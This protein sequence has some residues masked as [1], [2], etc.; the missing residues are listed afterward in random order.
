MIEQKLHEAQYYTLLADESKDMSER[1]QLSIAFRYIYKFRTVEHFVGFTLASELNARALA[2]Y[3]FQ[4]VSDLKLVLGNL[5]SQC[6]DG[7]SVMR[8]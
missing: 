1:E 8:E 3:I 6:Y 2:D 7:A 4:K 5:V